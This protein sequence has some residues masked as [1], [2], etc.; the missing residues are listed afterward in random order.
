MSESI[1]C[2]ESSSLSIEL[3]PVSFSPSFGVS[4]AIFPVS[5]S[6]SVVSL[7]P[8]VVASPSLTLCFEG[9]DFV[10]DEEALDAIAALSSLLSV[11]SRSTGVDIFLAFCASVFG[12][13]LAQSSDFSD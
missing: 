12:S 8:T 6:A 13:S 2:K 11:S 5:E 3:P 7:L 9:D 1:V 4:F 10:D